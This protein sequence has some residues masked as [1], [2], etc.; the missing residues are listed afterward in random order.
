MG[1]RTM[2]NGNR[3]MIPPPGPAIAVVV[4]L[5]EPAFREVLEL[6]D[7]D[8][9]LLAWVAGRPCKDVWVFRCEREPGSWP[10]RLYRYLV[11]NV[12]RRATGR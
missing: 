8:M 10:E 6:D 1:A 3:L 9:D 12:W 5:D 4:I 7:G 2:V 11:G